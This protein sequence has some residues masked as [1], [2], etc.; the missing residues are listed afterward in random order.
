M[1]TIFLSYAHEDRAWKERL[2]SY[3]RILA[4]NDDQLELEVWSDTE[5]EAGDDWRQRIDGIM[6]RASL[7]VLVV[8]ENFLASAFISKHELPYLEERRRNHDLDI[9]AVIAESCPWEMAVLLRTLQH[10]PSNAALGSL[11]EVDRREELNT[12]VRTV[13]RKL[14][15]GLGTTIPGPRPVTNGF[16]ALRREGDYVTLQLSLRHVRA[17][18]YSIE[19]RFSDP[20]GQCPNRE[21]R[22]TAFLDE[23]S[24][25]GG[26]NKPAARAHDLAQRLFPT[27]PPAEMF[28]TVRRRA[29]GRLLKLR[30]SLNPSA[31]DLHEVNWEV[32]HHH[33][34]A[35]GVETVF[36]RHVSADQ[37]IWPRPVIRSGPPSRSVAVLDFRNEPGFVEPGVYCTEFAAAGLECDHVSAGTPLGTIRDRDPAFVVLSSDLAFGHDDLSLSWGE[38]SRPPTPRPVR[39]AIE[40][41]RQTLMSTQV[42]I[43]DSMPS[44]TESTYP[45][46]FAGANLRLAAE[47]AAAGFCAVVTCAAPLSAALWVGFLQRFL[48]ALC[49]TGNIDLATRAARSAMDEES[50]SWKPVVFTRLRTGQIWFAPRFVE[51]TG[52]AWK[53]VVDRFRDKSVVPVVGPSIS[54]FL[55]HSRE[56]I[57]ERLAQEN[58]FPLSR[59][60]RWQLRKV[61]QYIATTQEP[62]SVVR[63]Y[64]GAVRTHCMSRYGPLLEDVAD[65]TPLRDL[66]ARL[67]QRG[68][69]RQHDNPYRL[70]ASLGVSIFLTTAVHD[71]LSQALSGEADR[72]VEVGSA[73]PRD[74]VFSLDQGIFQAG[75]EPDD[76]S[77]PP[78]QASPLVYYLFG[79]IDHPNSLV[80]TE[81]DHFRFLLRFKEQWR[82]LPGPVVDRLSDCALLFL[83]FK[84]DDWDFRALFR[85]FLELEGSNQLRRNPHVAVQVDPDDDRLADP[86]ETRKYLFE[87]FGQI[88]QKPLVFIGSASD[89]LR[90]LEQRL[91]P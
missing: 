22:Y 7:S 76:D 30:L 6:E 62:G 14:G 50:E 32:L 77:V 19:A 55:M 37:E 23:E 63:Q 13:Q 73:G 87:Y 33:L 5:L 91:T 53:V 34:N 2:A 57:A 25:G 21:L 45:K 9:V 29:A 86:E 17:A 84:L 59:F 82:S 60:E 70:L 67:W 43:L 8:T 44:G 54:S 64:L 36:V 51:S 48:E 83:G 71:F 39:E 46:G 80:L 26:V 56:E 27:G 20:S 78:G 85:A 31:S 42:L 18:Y 28:E 1:P 58:H 89:F 4:L 38:D 24:L 81:D 15:T 61:A 16:T 52:N 88:S 3:L 11:S 66:L 68:F 65:D 90:E 72:P 74:R 12:F 35:Q 69:D 75:D 41:L 40:D 10:I 49:D 47:I 79:R